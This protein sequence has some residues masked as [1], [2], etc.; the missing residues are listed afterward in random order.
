MTPI[1]LE[2]TLAELAKTVAHRRESSTSY[3]F[4]FAQAEHGT[5]TVIVA[6]TPSGD[7]V[8]AWT[9]VRE[10]PADGSLWI[11]ALR[12]NVDTYLTAIGT[13]SDTLMASFRRR[14][15]HLSKHEL[16]AAIDELV[17]V[18]RLYSGPALER[19]GDAVTRAIHDGPT[20][21]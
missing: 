7:V 9:E 3:E 1:E 18:S 20:K 21:N 19:A 15:G 14:I 2:D 8:A 4:D 10:L 16:L 17:R 13:I 5:C 12:A 11:A 6:V